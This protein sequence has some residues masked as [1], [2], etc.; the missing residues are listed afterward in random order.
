METI[1]RNPEYSSVLTEKDKSKF[2]NVQKALSIKE[3][4]I[5]LTMKIDR[6]YSV[7]G[8]GLTILRYRDA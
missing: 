1:F 8:S 7:P 2:K 5:V 4:V 6:E 3:S